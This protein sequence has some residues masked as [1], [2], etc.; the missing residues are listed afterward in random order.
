MDME[1]EGMN[2]LLDRY[3]NDFLDNFTN[4]LKQLLNFL[5]TSLLLITTYENKNKNILL[6]MY[7]MIVDL[8][9]I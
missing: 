7:K 3:P 5:S 2:N 6:N 9:A 4:E 1:V 8:N